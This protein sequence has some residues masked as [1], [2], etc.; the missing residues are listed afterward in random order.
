MAIEDHADADGGAEQ[1]SR[2]GRALA[3]GGFE[4]VLVIDRETARKILTEKRQELIARIREGD[5]ESVRGLADDLD[6]DIS[7]VSR[8]LDLLAVNDIVEYET[9]GRRKIP[10]LKHQTVVAEPVA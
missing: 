2:M 5:I 4:D 6:R 7:G 9:E 1:R 3:T 10:H 8:D